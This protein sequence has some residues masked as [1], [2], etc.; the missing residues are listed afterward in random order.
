MGESLV[1]KGADVL[2][3]RGH[4]YPGLVLHGTAIGGTSSRK[5]I[6]LIFPNQTPG[7][8]LCLTGLFTGVGWAWWSTA[9][10][11]YVCILGD[12]CDSPGK[13]CLFFLTVPTVCTALEAVYLERGLEVG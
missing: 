3:F 5:G 1:S 13:S 11:M 12:A 7:C 10:Y 6:G 8:C 9:T 4:A 2:S